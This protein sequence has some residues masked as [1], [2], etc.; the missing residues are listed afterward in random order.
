MI[1]FDGIMDRFSSVEDENIKNDLKL[2]KYMYNDFINT[3][4]A[5]LVENIVSIFLNIICKIKENKVPKKIIT[6]VASKKQFS[7]EEEMLNQFKQYMFAEG[8]SDRTASDYIRRLKSIVKEE[9]IKGGVLDLYNN[10]IDYYIDLY[11]NLKVD[12]SNAQKV[13]FNKEKTHNA[14]SASLKRLDAFKNKNML[15]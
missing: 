3:K 8:M 10:N 4:D 2:I 5:D 14:I 12:G 6:Y 13:N 15:D 1:N 9:N 11:T 7:N